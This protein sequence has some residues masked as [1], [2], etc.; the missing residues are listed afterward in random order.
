MKKNDYIIYKSTAA[1]AGDSEKPKYHIGKAKRPTEEGL[2]VLLEKDCHIEK[3]T[4]EVMKKDIVVNLGQDPSPG[5]VYGIDVTNLHRKSLS[6][7]SAGVDVHLFHKFDEKNESA[8]IKSLSKARR[9]LGK[10]GLDFVMDGSLPLFYEILNKHNKY[11]GMF[12]RG[13]KFS[14]VQLL[15][16]KDHEDFNEYVFLHELSHAIDSYLLNSAEIQAHWVRLYIRTIKPTSI[17]LSEVRKMFGSLKKCTSIS[18]WKKGFE[19]EDRGKPGLVLRAIKQAHG[20]RPRE[21]DAL[22]RGDDLESVKALWPSE[23]V[24]SSDLAP[25]VS[26]YACTN[27]RETIAESLSMYML[28]KKLPKSVVQLAED[29]IQY[30]IGQK[31]HVQ[32]EA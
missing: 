15:Y 24:R 8:I 20:V 23:D 3:Q 14:R 5:E 31:V 19:E 2:M 26:E 17:E 4:A 29:S 9:N 7:D 11:A 6:V 18:D 30:A 12:R 27:V 32:R 21:V 28:G 10:H 13:K 22:L 1:E 25:L 16:N